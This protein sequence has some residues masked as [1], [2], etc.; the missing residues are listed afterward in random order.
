[1]LFMTSSGTPGDKRTHKQTVKDAVYDAAKNIENEAEN[2]AEEHYKTSTR[3]SR[4]NLWL[5]LPTTILAALS[6]TSALAQ[7]DYHNIIAGIIA[8]VVA[9]LAAVSTFLNSNEKAERHQSAGDNYSTLRNLAHNLAEVDYWEKDTPALSQ[10]LDELTKQL[11]ELNKNSPMVSNSWR[12][13]KLRS[14]KITEPHPSPEES[15]T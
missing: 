2:V 10:K 12:Y 4:I 8:M 6:G 11:N 1:M 7:F 3:W 14:E 5:G 13:K 9:S 15:K